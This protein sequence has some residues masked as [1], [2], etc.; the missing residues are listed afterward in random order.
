MKIDI[1]K[2]V[3]Y[4]KALLMPFHVTPLITALSIV[5]SLLKLG[6]VPLGVLATANFI[7]SSLLAIQNRS[8]ES[9]TSAILWLSVILFIKLYYYIEEPLMNLVALK[10]QEKEW[11]L[12]DYP[13]MKLQASIDLKH[14][15]NS[16][17]S[18]LI[19]RMCRPA[20]ALC[21]MLGHLLTFIV[22]VGGILNYIVIL[23]INAP[24]TGCIILAAS[25]PIVIIARISALAQYKIKQDITEME[26]RGSTLRGYMESRDSAAERSLFSYFDFVSRKF[27]EVFFT[28]RKFVVQAEVNWSIK[29]GVAG[30]VL[31]LLC[32]LSIFALLP[33]VSAGTLAVGMFI[34]LVQSIFKGAEDIAYNLS[35]YLETFYTDSTFLKEYETYTEL[36]RTPDAT[37]PLSDTVCPFEELEFENVSFAYPGTET[38][39]LKDVSFKLTAGK[40]YSLVGLNG[41][42]KSTII[43][44]I[45]KFYD[46]YTGNILLNGRSIREWSLSDIKGMMGS[47]FQD[48]CRY[49]ISVK[50]NI[51]IGSGFTAG[52]DEINEAVRA[53]GL[54]RFVSELPNGINTELGKIYDDGENL[55]GGQWQKIAIA[56]IMVSHSTLRIFDEPTASLDPIAERELY[57]YFDSLSKD[58][59]S[60][61]ISHRLASCLH[62]D[63]ILLLDDGVIKERGSHNELMAM[64]GKYKEMFESQRE[65]YI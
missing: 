44:L 43:K 60:I 33:S 5:D 41:S 23:L 26:R 53:T 57:S 61:T 56:R 58:V 12:I 22:F 24:L 27:S 3:T 35:P 54:E 62:A 52:E 48:F 18:D 64:D 32:A 1:S 36:S 37:S 6:L 14:F 39:I 10:K 31:T 59:T 55:S 25:V 20:G 40:H 63:E 2:K 4:F 19:S 47:V 11:R 49:D 21:G 38:L 29:K 50:D 30:I 51:A 17:T 16:E 9:R 7:D 15:E 28:S 8:A 42:G 34:S 46:N 45:L 13:A 65:W